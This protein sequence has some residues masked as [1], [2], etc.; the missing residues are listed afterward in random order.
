MRLD[1]I[2]RIEAVVPEDYGPKQDPLSFVKILIHAHVPADTADGIMAMHLADKSVVI[3]MQ[4]SDD[5]GD[6]D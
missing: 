6:K 3:S 5:I 2:G 4:G 1:F